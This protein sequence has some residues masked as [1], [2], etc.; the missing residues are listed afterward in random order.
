MLTAGFPSQD[1]PKVGTQLGL[2]GK[3]SGLFFEIIRLVDECSDLEVA[4]LENADAL[5]S[6]EQVWTVV[7]DAFLERGFSARWVSVPATAVGCH[8]ERKRWF[9]LARRGKSACAP[10]ADALFPL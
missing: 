8:Q 9:F 3:R 6:L 2:Q 1:L 4:F 5:R 7:L 10:F